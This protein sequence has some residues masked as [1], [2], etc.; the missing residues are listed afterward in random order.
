MGNAR[1]LATSDEA[2]PTATGYLAVGDV[3][4]V[5]PGE[6]IPADGGILH[7]TAMIDQKTITGEG[8]PVRGRS[9]ILCLPPPS[10][11]KGK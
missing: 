6:M 2:A 1:L 7:G 5:N 11:A 4:V 9:A 8:L 10:C 3:V